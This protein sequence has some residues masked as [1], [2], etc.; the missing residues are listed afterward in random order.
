[1][2]QPQAALYSETLHL[3]KLS[4]SCQ[5]DFLLYPKR[6]WH[7][8][9]DLWK[10]TQW[11]MLCI[12]STSSKVFVKSKKEKRKKIN[13]MAWSLL[14][15]VA[16]LTVLHS[17]LHINRWGDLFTRQTTTCDSIEELPSACKLYHTLI[18]SLVI[19]MQISDRHSKASTHC[20]T[21]PGWCKGVTLQS[22]NQWA[23]IKGKYYLFFIE[24]QNRRYWKGPLEIIYSILPPQA[25]WASAGGLALG[26]VRS[27]VSP[28]MDII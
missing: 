2:P 6:W 16:V 11:D 10:R 24:L 8:T 14:W 21:E 1:M 12:L 27:W 23:E 20:A 17:F 3:E 28:R 15:T 25:W 18:T 5:D 22:K 9:S 7:A 26:L 13:Y 4:P 19:S